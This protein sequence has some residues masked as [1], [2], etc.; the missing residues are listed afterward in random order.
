MCIQI[1]RLLTVFC[2][3]L[4]LTFAQEVA[5]PNAANP[6]PLV[7]AEND[8]I[9]KDFHFADGESLPELKLHYRTIGHPASSSPGGEVKNAVL[10][11][12]GTTGTGKE[13]LAQSF[14]NA[15]FGPGQ[16]LDAAKYYL[17][18]PDAIGLGG[19]SKPSDGLHDRFPRYGYK[20]MVAAQERLV[21][22]GLGIKHLRLVFGTSMGGMHAWLWGE[23]YPALLDAIIPVACQPDKVAGRNLLWRRIISTA[24]RSD[25]EWNGGDYQRQ[26][27]SLARVYPIFELM[28]SNAAQ[29]QQELGS[30]EQVNAWLE[31]V[32]EFCRSGQIDANDL[33]HRLEASADY[34]PAPNLEKIQAA[35]LAIN[36]ADDE[37]NPPE[38][39][40]VDR[41]KQRI[42]NGQFVLIPASSQTRGHMTLRKASIYAPFVADF[43]AK[44]PLAQ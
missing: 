31:R 34:D 44:L 14:R 22:E 29:F 42:R 43:L 36:F 27:S 32:A 7:T 23:Q 19:S 2:L 21:T 40:I 1:L 11:I 26:P 13:F 5:T 39:G 17:I 33:V 38:L 35:V 37:L 9:L 15:M 18:L 28:T 8:F 24:V 6:D 30:V 16:P 3:Q 12:H 41:A 10:L 4:S 25:P 20:D